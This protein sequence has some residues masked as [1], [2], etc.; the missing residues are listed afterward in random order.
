MCYL[1]RFAVGRTVSGLPCRRT[2][3]FRLGVKFC[4]LFFSEIVALGPYRG[5]S[6]LVHPMITVCRG[7]GMQSG[8][9]FMRRLFFR[10]PPRRG[11]PKRTPH[12]PSPPSFWCVLLYGSATTHELRRSIIQALV[13]PVARLCEVLSWGT[14]TSHELRCSIAQTSVY[15]LA[16]LC[17][18]VIGYGHEPRAALL[19]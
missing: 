15:Y 5:S 6:D 18:I 9:L 4:L 16:R 12:P 3:T 7:N 11:D 2:P 8:F 10:T 14:A 1:K 13:D 17:E 19:C